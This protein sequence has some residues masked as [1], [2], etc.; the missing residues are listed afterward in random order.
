MSRLPDDSGTSAPDTSPHDM[1]ALAP[2]PMY[3]FLRQ[4]AAQNAWDYAVDDEHT[5]FHRFWTAARAGA[6]AG[7]DY[8]R[9]TQWPRGA[10][11]VVP[12]GNTAAF[13]FLVVYPAADEGGY[14]DD[15]DS[16]ETAC[17]VR[18]IDTLLHRHAGCAAP[19]EIL[20]AVRAALGPYA[21]F[22]EAGLAVQGVADA[23][24]RAVSGFGGAVDPRRF[25][26]LSEE[27]TFVFLQQG[28]AR[29]AWA[30]PEA[31][32]AAMY[33]RFW[34][35]ARLSARRGTAYTRQE[36]TAPDDVFG[37]TE[38]YTLTVPNGD[39][40]MMLFVATAASD[41]ARQVAPGRMVPARAATACV[42]R[43]ISARLHRHTG[44]PAA[45]DFEPGQI[46]AIAHIPV[47]YQQ[48]VYAGLIPQMLPPA[49][50][51]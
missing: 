36:E 23:P 11:L 19:T 37:N 26:A 20:P 16:P 38:T 18:V 4:G 34:A 29:D 6:R 14:A 22:A 50:S 10:T 35:A 8:T 31:G 43:V 40:G 13:M 49:P 32:D 46:R 1:F 48:L 7:A 47:A 27:A 9:T 33:A 44:C 25:F 39:V 28:A 12:D 30:Y 51:A 24:R 3:V 45:V 42:V 17:A 2:Q 41:E 15:D 21:A 5:A